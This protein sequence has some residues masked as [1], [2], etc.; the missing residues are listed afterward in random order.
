MNMAAEQGVRR[1][2]LAHCRVLRD[3][4]DDDEHYRW[5]SRIL[6]FLFL[7]W[8]LWIGLGARVRPTRVPLPKGRGAMLTKKTV[9]E[10]EKLLSEFEE[11]ILPYKLLDLYDD[12][13]LLNSLL[14]EW[15][16]KMYEAGR[17]LRDYAST[18][19][20]VVDGKRSV[21]LQMTGAWDLARLWAAHCPPEHRLAMPPLLLV[22]WVVI[23]LSWGWPRFASLV[24]LGWSAFLR[25]IEFLTASRRHLVLPVDVQGE[26]E[27]AFL[28]IP[29]P[30]TR[31]RG[32]RNQ[33]ARTDE[34]W[35]IRL[36]T[37]C[38]ASLPKEEKL[39][40]S[41]PA[42]FRTRWQAIGRSLGI[43]TSAKK[44][45]TPASLRPGGVTTFFR[46]T[47]DVPR[48]CQRARWVDHRQLDTYVQEVSPIEYLAALPRLT[49][50][51]LD[52]LADHLPSFI[53]LAVSLLERGVPT[54]LWPALFRTTT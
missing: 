18:I 4:P 3:F 30:K 23:A 8:L 45:L 9:S 46:L 28:R 40:P 25:P 17:C 22:G 38:F 1:P 39:W 44:G 20:A 36:L 34:L 48:L 49:R 2:H 43:D 41:S 12:L 15:G 26:T 11:S 33:I 32:A 42:A 13:E 19:L 52:S 6:V 53:D 21:R 10:R 29:E 50:A 7:G 5:P 16:R 54:K 14:H 47:E 51:R 35:V 24:A 27:A 37:A 31:F